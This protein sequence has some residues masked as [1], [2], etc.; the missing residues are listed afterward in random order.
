MQ[1][2]DAEH[3]EVRRR[4]RR[5][6]QLLG[7]AL[8]GEVG[9][10][11]RHTRPSPR[12]TSRCAPNRGSRRAT[13]SSSSC[14]RLRASPTASRANRARSYGSGLISTVW[15]AENT[16]VLAP[17]ASASV[18]T[19]ISAGRGLAAHRANRVPQIVSK[20]I[21]PPASAFVLDICR[22]LA[23]LVP[24]VAPRADAMTKDVGHARAHTRNLAAPRA[25]CSDCRNSAS[26]SPPNS[27]AEIRRTQTQQQS[28]E[29]AACLHG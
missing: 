5:H 15:T 1:R 10:D 22:G 8:A 7:I 13:P 6:C 21:H 23:K 4:H 2:P 18:S 27:P 20:R 11:F 14:L 28:I 19:M 3:V 25:R 9:S 29:R 26:I 16:A 12:T 24:G 17:I